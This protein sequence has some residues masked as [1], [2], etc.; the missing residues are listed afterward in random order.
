MNVISIAPKPVNGLA[1][2]LRKMADAA[3]RGDLIDIVYLYVDRTDGTYVHALTCSR[4]DAVALTAML[5]QSAI[6]G[7]RE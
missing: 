4:F 1:E 5:H 2:D 3:D 6:D 7:M